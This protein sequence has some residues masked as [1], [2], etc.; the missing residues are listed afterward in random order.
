M[1]KNP[2][3]KFFDTARTTRLS[4]AER[5]HIS[6]KLDAY[7]KAHPVRGDFGSRLSREARGLLPSPYQP[8]F[9]SMPA[10]LA[11][12]VAVMLGGG[13]SL[14][15]EGSFPGDTLY[16]IKVRVNETV[17]T[18]LT[19]SSGARANLEAEFASKRLTEAET[20]AKRGELSEETAAEL[21][22]AFERHVDRASVEADADESTDTHLAAADKAELKAK[23]SA[24]QR[25]LSTLSQG[26]AKHLSGLLKSVEARLEV[27]PKRPATPNASAETPR[28]TKDKVVTSG[29]T[30]PKAIA[31]QYASLELRATRQ[32]DAATKAIAK[33]ESNAKADAN[34]TALG[35]AKLSLAT[36]LL[37]EAKASFDQKDT[38][39]AFAKVLASIEA[40]VEATILAKASN[41]V[42]ED[43]E[44]RSLVPPREI[45]ESE[46]DRDTPRILRDF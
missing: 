19:F 29:E 45:L 8:Y 46:I 22:R 44:V 15:A 32:I 34:S 16:P 30:I 21:S 12:V 14:A 27:K 26:N 7:L 18:A 28:E 6:K 40:S 5:A 2:D 39:Q 38:D 35:V 11:L 10:V 25:I 23:L 41:D 37:A 33:A 20:L 17:Q 13:T 36:S 24:H 3:S 4:D 42:L 43:L 9:T 1:T 31:K